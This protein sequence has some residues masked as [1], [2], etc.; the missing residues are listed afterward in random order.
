MFYTGQVYFKFIK[1]AEKKALN[2]FYL[3]I[4][5]Y[6]LRYAIL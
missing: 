4:A 6:L 1:K 2:I 3:Q 5:N